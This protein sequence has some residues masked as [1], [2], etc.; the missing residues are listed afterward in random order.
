MSPF[1]KCFRVYP[2]MMHTAL[3]NACLIEPLLVWL[4]ATFGRLQFFCTSEGD[5]AM[6]GLKTGV[7]LLMLIAPNW[8]AKVEGACEGACVGAT[9]RALLTAAVLNKL[10]AADA[11]P[12][13]L[14]A[15]TAGVGRPTVDPGLRRDIVVGPVR[16]AD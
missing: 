10:L 1:L 15:G 2:E 16:W 7:E 3:W 9:E 11:P 13:H 12:F 5:G 8:D 4:G 14:L 6:D